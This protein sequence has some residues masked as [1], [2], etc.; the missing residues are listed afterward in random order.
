MPLFNQHS[1][2]S[3]PPI[4]AYDRY[5]MKM[6]IKSKTSLLHKLLASN[7]M[8]AMIGNQMMTVWNTLLTDTLLTEVLFKSIA[9]ERSSHLWNGRWIGG[10]VGCVG[11]WRVAGRLR[12]RWPRLSRSVCWW[13]RRRG[14]FWHHWH[15]LGRGAV[16]SLEWSE[17][18]TA[19]K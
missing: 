8:Q 5:H 12:P 18:E 3:G 13:S 16:P 6:Q 2:L 19:Q 1:W 9:N 7:Q 4:I 14:A 10:C 15:H 11:H 17:A